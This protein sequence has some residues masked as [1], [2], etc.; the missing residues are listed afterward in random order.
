MPEIV[1]NGNH[2]AIARWRRE[3]S[4]KNTWEKRPELLKNALL[5]EKDKWYLRTLGWTEEL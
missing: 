1:T 5:N 4:L 3:M 2:A